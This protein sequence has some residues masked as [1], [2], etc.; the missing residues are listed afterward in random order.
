MAGQRGMLPTH[1][2]C[3]SNTVATVEYL[4]NLYP[5]AVEAGPGLYPIHIA[6]GCLIRREA[7]TVEMM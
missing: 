2:A 1:F 7:N 4:Y 3:M 5:D 6:F